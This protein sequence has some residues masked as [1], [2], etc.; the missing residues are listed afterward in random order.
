MSPAP[1]APPAP[2]IDPSVVVLGGQEIPVEFKDGRPAEY[3]KVRILEIEHF[4]RFIDLLKSEHELADFVCAQPP[5]WSA[6]VTT[7][8]LLDIAEKAE[9]LNFTRALRWIERRAGV[10][11]RLAP[12]NAAAKAQAAGPSASP[13]S[14]PASA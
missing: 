12:A 14:A 13:S 9:A 4:G 5:G 8:S 10:L 6:T 3:V 7:D 1:V 2:V 11:S